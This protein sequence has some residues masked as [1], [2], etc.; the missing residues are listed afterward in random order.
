MR[1]TET[2]EELKVLIFVKGCS[3]PEKFDSLCHPPTRG[4]LPP[5]S[6]QLSHNPTPSTFPRPPRLTHIHPSDASLSP[7]WLLPKP[8]ARQSFQS[9]SPTVVAFVYLNGGGGGGGGIG[10]LTIKVGNDQKFFW[11]FRPPAYKHRPGASSIFCDALYNNT[12][13]MRGGG[14]GVN[15]KT[16]GRN[17]SGYCLING[18]WDLFRLCPPPQLSGC[19]LFATPRCTCNIFT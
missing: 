10:Y 16:R 17:R 8:T 4:F 3:Q 12:I 6:V 14:G 1:F 7:S 19:I 18:L 11:I 9:N 5:P 15:K 13:C 2:L